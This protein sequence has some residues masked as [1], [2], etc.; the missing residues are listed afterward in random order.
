MFS[1][2]KIPN[3]HCALLFVLFHRENI[4]LVMHNINKVMALVTILNNW[5]FWQQFVVMPPML[6]EMFIN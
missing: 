6:M 4:M 5:I 3:L 1:N 2:M